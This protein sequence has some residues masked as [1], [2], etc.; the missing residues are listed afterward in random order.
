MSEQ[1]SLES[2]STHPLQ[3]QAAKKEFML[4][5]RVFKTDENVIKKEE[6]VSFF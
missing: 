2:S 1:N 6:A 5:R 3:T 4:W